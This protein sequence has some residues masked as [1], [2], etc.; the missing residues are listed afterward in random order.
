ML[1]HFYSTVESM[2]IEKQCNDIISFIMMSIKASYKTCIVNQGFLIHIT[3]KASCIEDALMSIQ[4]RLN[5]TKQILTFIIF[6]EVNLLHS[7][8]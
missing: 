2:E 7:C 3:I 6:H 8:L 1:L 5:V 4:K